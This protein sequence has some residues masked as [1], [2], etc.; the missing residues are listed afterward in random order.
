MIKTSLAWLQLNHQKTRL[1]IALAGVGFADMLMFI[2]LGFQAALFESN[3]RF[4]KSFRGD[5]F[6]ISPDSRSTISMEAFSR[7]RIYQSLAIEGVQSTTTV[8]MDFASWKNPVNRSTRTLLIV[9]LNPDSNP[10]NL[11]G[12][13]KTI[14][15][16]KHRDVYLFDAL[17]REEFGPVPSLLEEKKSVT[18]EINDH[19]VKI[20]GLF[21][22]GASFAADGNLITSDINFHR[23]LPDRD[24]SLIDVG[25]IHLNEN[26]DLQLVQKA[27]T[28]KLPPDVRI[29]SKEEFIEWEKHYWKTSTAIGFIFSMG[30]GIGF[31][32]GVL[33]VYQILYTD[34]SDRLP[35]YATLK[36][37]GYKNRYFILVVFQEAI[38]LA[39]LGYIPGISITM[40][41]YSLAAG[42]TNLPI[43]M[44]ITRAITV[45]T[46]TIIMC[47]VSGLIAIRRLNAADPSDLY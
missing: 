2:Q 18:A 35:E 22:L 8:Y 34:I 40:I 1:L 5:L 14:A 29:L 32:V 25:V 43:I 17:S 20:G 47:S 4:H 10:L 7:T 3:V 15:S 16:I 23:L 45:L 11:P 27:L 41:L 26:A 38:I 6:L 19:R 37:I 42:A 44:T 24:R 36:A 12:L 33:I 21:A 39:I 46:L 9:G 28:E 13:S 31:M 30:T